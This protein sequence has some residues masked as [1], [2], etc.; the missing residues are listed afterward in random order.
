MHTA[1]ICLAINTR[2]RQVIG[3]D[4]YSEAEPP[5]TGDIRLMGV[6][7]IDGITYGLAAKAAR[8]MLA[9]DGLYGW[10]GPWDGQCRVSP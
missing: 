5:S 9:M 7:S 8:G 2:T 4:V 10:I 3:A 6:W 1:W